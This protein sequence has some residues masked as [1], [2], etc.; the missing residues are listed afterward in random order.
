MGILSHLTKQTNEEEL[1]SRKE[2]KYKGSLTLTLVR[3]LLLFTLLPLS[4]MGGVTYIRT[5]ALLREQAISE[6]QLVMTAQLK[7]SAQA[8]ELK[9]KRLLALVEDGQFSTALESAFHANRQSSSFAEIRSSALERFNS[10]NSDKDKPRFDEFFLL[11]PDGTIEISTNPKWEGIL[12][13]DANVL[14]RIQKD[15]ASILTYNLSPLYTD[16]PALLT[17]IQYRTPG[18]SSLGT[19]VG[20]TEA[21]NLKPILQSVKDLRPSSEPYFFIPPNILIGIDPQTTA[22]ILPQTSA[23][24]TEAIRTAF[25]QEMEQ[26][27]PQ[28]LPIEYTTP[29][30]RKTLAQI[31]WMPGINAGVVLE[32]DQDVIFGQLNSL[33]PFMAALALLVLIGMGLVIWAGANRVI[34]PLQ[35]LAVIAQKYAK[36]DWSQRAPVKTKDEIGWLA[37][38]FNNMADQLSELYQSLEQKVDEQTRQI[39]TASEVAQSVIGTTSLDE[40]LNKTVEIIVN[41]FGYYHAGIFLLD[42]TGKYAALRAAYGPAASEMLAQGHKL[43]VGSASIIGWVTANNQPHIASDVVEDPIHLKNDFLPETRSEIGVPIAVGNMVVGAL[44]VQSRQ[45]NAF[46]PDTATVV[47]FQTLASQI[48]S[49]IQNI[50]LIEATQINIQ[51]LERLYR[52]SHLIA[53]TETEETA[54]QVTERILSEA[55]YQHVMLGVNESGFFIRSYAGF[56][57]EK[58]KTAERLLE[59]G[60]AAAQISRYLAGN[61]PIIT[62]PASEPKLGALTRFAHELGCQAAAFLPI[63][64]N[65]RLASIIMLG[66]TNQTLSNTTIQPYA[67]MSELLST[68]LEK[69][70]AA[71][72]TEQRLTEMGALAALS[73]TVSASSNLESFYSALH[74]QVKRL[75]GDY[76]FTVAL[77]DAKTD[78]ISI[79]FSYEDGRVS[80]IE[81]F[82]LGQGLTSILIRTKKPLMLV[83]DTEKKALELGAKIVGHPARS[84]MGTPL[85]IQNRPIGALII[86]DL[87]NDHAFTEDNLRFFTALASQVAGVIYNVILLDES[88]RRAI[89]LQTAAEIARDISASQNLDELLLKAVN[90]IR[91]RFNFYHASVYLLDLTGEYAV[92]REATGEAGAQLKRNGHKLGVGSKSIIGYVSSRGEPLVVNDTS[93]DAT[94]LPN[95]LLPETRAEASIPLKVGERILGVLDVQSSA[96]FM[97]AEDNLRTLQILADQLAIAVVNAELF[98]ET[99]EHLSQHRLLHHITTAS[100]SGSTLEEALE[101]AVNGLQVSL[102]GDRVSILLADK[103]KRNLEVMA[104]VG[105]SEDVSNFKVQIGSGI[106]GWAAAHRRSLRVDD[107]RNDSRY[108]Q[109]SPNTRSELAVPLVYRNELLGVLNVESEQPNAYSENDE[110][111]LGTLGGS[112]AAII[113]NARLLEQ[114]RHQAERERA[115]FEIT[116]KIRRSSDMETILNTTASELS[117]VIGAQRTRIKIELKDGKD[118]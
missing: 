62:A 102:G 86:Q 31:E 56:N 28:P 82:P 89:Q 72:Q 27:V 78:T 76:S 32:M 87:E 53:E 66:A 91:D 25:E 45:P 116:N 39:R 108:I 3:T 26:A 23:S 12:I 34:R 105:Y 29:N 14:P 52:T 6:S 64:C 67:Q 18:G 38:S 118:E 84:W 96:P 103:D 46:G 19:V 8:I 109:A 40:L 113:A 4:I 112:L 115:L 100:A 94:F 35:T 49:A 92:I 58:I 107:V 10:L 117:R 24:Q 41:Q 7:Q 1:T 47:M 106:T 48:A 9:E 79:P 83:E 68:T 55:P 75:I 99:Q 5:R 13:T 33:A 110:E 22:F 21:Q 80:A 65:E 37:S 101:S 61:G 114:I 50:R 81:S 59:I 73:Q 93:N 20:V 90:L 11:S 36:G 74:E 16:Q 57:E 44:D 60:D 2:T 77:Y 63:K 51:E 98:A 104:S 30:G 85:L 70:E 15:H 17:A 97:F 42:G 71:K 43:E 54:L 95:P 69:I 111:M 88:Q